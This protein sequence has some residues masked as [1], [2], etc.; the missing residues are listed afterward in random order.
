MRTRPGPRVIVV[1]ARPGDSDA[2]CDALRMWGFEPCATDDAEVALALASREAPR[3]LVIDLDLPRHD[4]LDVVQA[5]RA[6]PPTR[7]V[8]VIALTD[9]LREDL[10]ELATGRGCDTVLAR[11]VDPDEVAAEAERL[12]CRARAA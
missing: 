6:H 1:S 2:C 7:D 3:A 12:L 4:P 11:P 9:V 8:A 10:A 5:L